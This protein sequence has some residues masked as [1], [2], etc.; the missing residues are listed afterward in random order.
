M[1]RACSLGPACAGSANSNDTQPASAPRRA[2][3][4]WTCALLVLTFMALDDSQI[5][6]PMRDRTIRTVNPAPNVST[7]CRRWPPTLFVVLVPHF[8]ALLNA[9]Q[10][11]I[12]ITAYERLT[13]YLVARTARTRQR[14]YENRLKRR[15][16]V[17]NSA[18]WR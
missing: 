6:C 5:K 9:R 2:R 13:V 16:A 18:V 8:S 12:L 15:G 3:L 14:C 1:R 7:V 17:M 4:A 10:T 11:A